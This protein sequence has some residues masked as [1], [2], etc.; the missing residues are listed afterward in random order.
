MKRIFYCLLLGSI[1][2][3]SAIQVKDNLSPLRP[4]DICSI[5]VP[6]IKV[7]G[8]T[9]LELEKLV[10][11]AIKDKNILYGEV[12]TTVNNK[13]C[14]VNLIFHLESFK[15]E[16]GSY[17]YSMEYEVIPDILDVAGLMSSSNG[18]SERDTLMKYV[19]VWDTGINGIASNYA[20]LTEAAIVGAGKMF[21]VF[22][23]DWRNTH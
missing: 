13:D 1:T 17:I 18:G 11:K 9:D 15:T 5:N 22:L 4:Y 12:F 8:K 14:A 19:V 16:A 3:S 20:K 21:E 10:S 2:A 7:E 6:I 23:L